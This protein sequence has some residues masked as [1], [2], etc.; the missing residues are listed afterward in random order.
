MLSSHKSVKWAVTAIAVVAAMMLASAAAQADKVDDYITSEMKNRH[1]PG[2][3]LAVVKNGEVIKA[4][5]YGLANVELNVPVTPDSVFDLASIT[6]SFTA[7]AIMM[8]VEE[9][10][11]GLD[12]R[13]S[14][15]LIN[16]PYTWRD[17][18]V[19]HLLTH[20]AGLESEGDFGPT[21]EKFEYVSKRPLDFAPGERMKY[22]NQG[23]FLLGMIIEKVSGK[24]WHEFLAERIFEPLGMT[25]TT[26]PD[27][28]DIIKNRAAHYTLRDGKLAPTWWFIY[29][30]E[31]A[32]AGGILSTVQDLAKWDAAIYTEKILKKSSLEQMWTPVKFNSG[33]GHTYGFGWSLDEIRN[34]RT[35]GHA[36]SSGTYILRL[37]DDKLTVI[38]LSNLNQSRSKPRIIAQGVAAHYL[39]AIRL[40]SLKAQPDPDPQMTQ[41]MRKLL[42]DIANG[43]TDS[44]LLTPERNAR[45]SPS[46]RRYIAGVSSLKG[47]KSFTFLVCDDVQGRQIDRYGVRVSRICYYKLVDALETRY[48]AFYLTADNKVAEIRSS[49]E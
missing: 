45:V 11:V 17:I 9:G 5:G 16:A 14:K 24:R 29:Q 13:I 30:D 38:V 10:K 22:S 8:L 4:K 35:V 31:L 15:Y 40:S 3:A 47:V 27:P 41:K 43:V 44:P 6:K 36:G 32:S 37:P 34:H 20:T 2:L 48:L 23:Y 21:A 25:A 7:T 12:D 1:I 26:V 33:F 39:P 42:S 18:T 28:W 46:F 49:T 19:R